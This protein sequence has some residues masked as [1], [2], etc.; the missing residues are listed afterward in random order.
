MSAHAS[1]V[2]RRSIPP[3]RRKRDRVVPD[4]HGAWAFLVLPVALGL[5][6]VGWSAA[7]LVVVVSWV[8]VYPVSWAL[9]G[10]LAAPRPERFRRALV[11]WSAVAVPAAAAA[12]YLRP[13]LLYVGLVYVAL[14]LVNLWFARRRRER[15]IANDLV[16]VAEC[17]AMVPIVAGV[18][19][20]G[21]WE[22][23]FAR[24]SEPGV[25][26]LALACAVA[27]VGSTLHVK[28]LIRERRNPRYAQASR[29]YAVGS[30]GVMA[31]AVAASGVGPAL[32]VPF[33]ALAVR[34][35]V[36]RDPRLRPATIGLVELACLLLLAGAAFVAV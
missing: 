20:G 3:G 8:A 10:I 11:V 13:W 12:A 5:A 28:S 36:V 21:G 4:Q 14:F 29:W 1:A 32:V 16:L 7:V 35:L 19:A 6:A 24:M 18:V 17:A 15:A 23:P 31:V 25:L 2:V 26:V 30:V 9:T 22:V 33:L 27:L 34:A